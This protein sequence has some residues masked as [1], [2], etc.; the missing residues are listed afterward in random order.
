M[1][2]PAFRSRRS[3]RSYGAERSGT[4]GTLATTLWPPTTSPAWLDSCGPRP[5]EDAAADAATG[6]LASS[7]LVP[8]T[9]AQ[10]SRYL[11]R[12]LALNLRL[13][14]NDPPTAGRDR[15]PEARKIPNNP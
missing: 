14:L 9:T 4:P 13:R 6:A 8:L 1:D 2:T 7:I 3:A 12:E 15:L 11:P 10:R 5:P